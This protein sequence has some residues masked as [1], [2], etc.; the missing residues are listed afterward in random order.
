MTE[1][2]REK[3]E[4]VVRNYFAKLIRAVQGPGETPNESV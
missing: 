4:A 1:E 3:K 2:E